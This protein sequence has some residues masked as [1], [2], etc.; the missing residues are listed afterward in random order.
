M[1]EEK[2][3]TENPESE[4]WRE[5]LQYSYKANIERYFNEHTLT[6]DD[7]KTDSI[8]GSFL[9][10]HEYYKASENANLHIMN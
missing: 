7:K 9:Q 10:A 3:F 5:L 2:M 8:I 4:L 6:Y 1:Y